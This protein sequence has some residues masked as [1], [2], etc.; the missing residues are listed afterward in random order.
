MRQVRI[1]FER[2]GGNP[3]QRNDL[4]VSTHGDRI[5]AVDLLH[6]DSSRTCRPEARA[7]DDTQVKK[8][9]HHGPVGRASTQ[10][11]TEFPVKKRSSYTRAGTC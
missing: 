3:L 5:Q 2:N 6:S 9:G 10:I 11:A 8:P 7:I 4:N 1:K